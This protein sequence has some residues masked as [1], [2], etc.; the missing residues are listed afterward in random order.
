MRVRAD[1]PADSVEEQRGNRNEQALQKEPEHQR[2]FGYTKVRLR[3]LAKNPARLVTLF[4]LSNR[5][6]RH[7]LEQIKRSTRFFR[8]GPKLLLD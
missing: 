3:G 2:Q 1:G 4:A 5:W 8:E 7:R 6:I